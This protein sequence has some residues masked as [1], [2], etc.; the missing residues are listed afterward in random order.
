[1]YQKEYFFQKKQ[2]Q[3]AQRFFQEEV[4]TNT[5]ILGALK[6]AGEALL[7]EIPDYYFLGL[8]CF[9]GIN[10]NKKK[11]FK[12]QT[13]SVNL[14][15]LKK[16]GL[17]VQDPKKKTYYLSPEGEKLVAY[18]ENRYEI[19]NQPWDKKIRIVIFDI[20]E[21]KRRWRYWLRQEL[22]LLQFKKLQQSVYIGKRPLP[23][24]FYKEIQKENLSDKIFVLTVGKID[25]EKEI[26][27]ILETIPS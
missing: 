14:S 16:Q 20:P 9:L 15:R 11:Q 12:K 18:I 21:K 10:K 6:E 13:L 22:N 4:T 3:F 26:A 27:A 19:L 24:S 7:D 5:C 17:V 23:V 2:R 8:R 1:M 25:R